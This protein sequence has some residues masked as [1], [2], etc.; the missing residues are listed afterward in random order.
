MSYGPK[1]TLTKK[2][3]AQLCSPTPQKKNTNSNNKKM[4]NLAL[5]A[6]LFHKTVQKSFNSTL[7]TPSLVSSKGGMNLLGSC[8]IWDTDTLTKLLHWI[9]TKLSLWNHLKYT[10]LSHILWIREEKNLGVRTTKEWEEQT[11]QL[12]GERNLVYKECNK[13]AAGC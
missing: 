10:L 9:W 2:E 3:T 4:L 13:I 11:D 8:I 7:K 1:K 12:T 6:I 5:Q